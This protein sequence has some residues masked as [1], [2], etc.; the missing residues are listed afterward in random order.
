M[1][2]Q[3]PVSSP[4]VPYA[5]HMRQRHAYNDDSLTEPAAPRWPYFTASQPLPQDSTDLSGL[6]NAASPC[7]QDHTQSLDFQDLD[8][9]IGTQD[10][11]SHQGHIS[12][13]T[14]TDAGST[15]S[16]SDSASSLPIDPTEPWDSSQEVD[17]EFWENHF[18]CAETKINQSFQTADTVDGERWLEPEHLRAGWSDTFTTY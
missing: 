2:S 15:M 5:A 18:R 12:Q 7:Y 14:S 3:G 11:G 10:I 13:E 9:E 8:N 16:R 4:N 6:Q 1:T 17:I